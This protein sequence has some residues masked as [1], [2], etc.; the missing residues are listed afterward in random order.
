MVPMV[1]ID[2]AVP[3]MIVGVPDKNCRNKMKLLFLNTPDGANLRRQSG[4]HCDKIH[5][6]L[7]GTCLLCGAR[8]SH[9]R[10]SCSQG[11]G[12]GIVFFVC[13]TESRS[14]SGSRR[15]N[16]STLSEMMPRQREHYFL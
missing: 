9:F 1:V 15:M 3:P 7:T 11:A 14:A 13:S 8:T 10:K 4:V 2:A 5:P 16:K 6:D 12:G